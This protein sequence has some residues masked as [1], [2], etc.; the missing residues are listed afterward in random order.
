MDMGEG[1]SNS[2]VNLGD[3][4]KPATVLIKKISDAIG[5][6]ARPGQIRRV[7]KAE[8]DAEIIKAEARVKITDI[9]ER[10][11]IR[12]VREEGQK[13]ENIENIT[14]KA[15]PHLS[16]DAKPENVEKDWLTNFFDRCRL[17]SDE[18]MQELWASILSGEANK[19]GAFSK[20][21]IEIVSTLSKKDADLFTKLCTFAWMIGKVTPVILD[22]QNAIYNSA[23]INF[24]SLLHLEDIGLVKFENLSGF[25]RKVP[26][27]YVSIFYYGRPLTIEFP[28]NK[29]H[30]E[31]GKV[32]LTQAGQEL[33]SICGSAQSDDYYSYVISEWQKNGYIMSSPILAKAVA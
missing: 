13:Q 14:A 4:S 33:A 8:A 27:K 2:L 3:L 31:L 9:E 16:Q 10:A 24:N 15:I 18:Q 1:S 20:R 28:D 26:D 29:P 30:I 11:L 12:M 22:S 21:T 19:P 25:I 5:G 7:A 6:I 23:G 17:T 32:L